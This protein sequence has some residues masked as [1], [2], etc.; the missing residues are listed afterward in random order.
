MGDKM[1]MAVGASPLDRVAPFVVHDDFLPA[2]EHRALLDWTLEQEQDFRPSHL[3]TGAV[4]AGIRSSGR[5]PAHH[6]QPWK[7]RFASRIRTLLPDLIEGLAIQPLACKAIELELARHND[8]DFYRRHIDTAL[9]SEGRAGTRTIS[10]VYYF[11]AEP[12]GFSGGALRLHAFSRR[13][14]NGR[15]SDIVPVQNR[16]VAFPSWAP[17]EV[18]PINCPSGR[19]EDSRFSINCWVHRTLPGQ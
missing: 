9:K 7:E 2:E 12:Q 4:D 8:G 1:A 15:F 13:D 16:L 19:F 5:L 14:G 18:M 11:H 3:G 10:A 17:H 6:D